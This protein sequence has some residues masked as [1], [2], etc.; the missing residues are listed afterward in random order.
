VFTTPSG[1]NVVSSCGTTWILPT[2]DSAG[3]SARYLPRTVDA[4]RRRQLLL[5]AL[6][7]AAVF[8][9][10]LEAGGGEGQQA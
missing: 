2:G 10:S 9:F 8:A 1:R 4:R 6:L 7:A 3:L 5:D